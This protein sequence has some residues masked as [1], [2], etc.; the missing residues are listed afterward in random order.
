LNFICI[1]I[2]DVIPSPS[3]SVSVA[4]ET[5]E[6]TN[7]NKSEE[8]PSPVE[9]VEPISSQMEPLKLDV[10]TERKRRPSSRASSHYSHRASHPV[11]K[12]LTLQGEK[13]VDADYPQATTRT[14]PSSTVCCQRRGSLKGQPLITDLF[15]E[16]MPET[17][18]PIVNP[19]PRPPP[20]KSSTMKFKKQR[21]GFLK[22]PKPKKPILTNKPK[23]ST[24]V[25]GK[26]EVK[27][28][29]TNTEINEEQKTN[30]KSLIVIGGT[31]WMMTLKPQVIDD[32]ESIISPLFEPS[33]SDDEDIPF[34]TSPTD[35]LAVSQTTVMTSVGDI[36]RRNSIESNQ[37]IE[38]SPV[39]TQMIEQPIEPSTESP[40]QASK[41][42]ESSLINSGIRTVYETLQDS[43]RKDTSLRSL[44]LQS[45]EQEVVPVKPSSMTSTSSQNKTLPFETSASATQT[46]NNSDTGLSIRPALRVV[47]DSLNSRG[48]NS[49]IR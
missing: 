31:D 39:L 28:Q 32:Q 44:L 20:I 25:I 19:E 10:P 14:I 8:L 3:P 43:I 23:T 16:S 49:M 40:R 36:Q 6:V 29:S 34:C 17:Q 33:I 45:N 38:I 47:N 26:I 9:D 22:N 2:S 18:N 4:I 46:Y 27:C 11:P 42:N 30:E 15:E 5:S 24:T 48:K 37:A 41:P 1:C 7:T 35:H 21:P 12:P 13:I